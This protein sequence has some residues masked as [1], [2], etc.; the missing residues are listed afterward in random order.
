MQKRFRD[1]TEAG[2]HLARELATYATN[3][4]D[5]I[6]LG[7]PRGGIPVAAEVAKKL[8]APLDV[9]VVRKLGLPGYRELA[10][11]AIA[12]GG[13]RI[14]N[15]DV[16]E[17]LKVPSEVIEAITAQ[18]RAELARRETSYRGNRPPPDLRDKT[19]IVVDDGIATGSSMI[20]AVAALRQSEARQIIVAA[21][22]IAPSTV[23]EIRERADETAVV[24][25]PDDFAGVGQ[26][27]EDFS[28]TTDDEVRAILAQVHH[29]PAS[30]RSTPPTA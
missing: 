18:E 17:S 7:L 24:M 25:T 28:Q 21:P 14:L 3:Q 22:V 27:Y 5:V 12:T 4:A 23:H 9:L 6:I 10:M 19:V 13:V 30:P 11:G 26:Y 2:E 16:V 1:R 8:H 29:F 15:R 20:A